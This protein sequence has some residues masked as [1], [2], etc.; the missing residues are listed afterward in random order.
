VSNYRLV[1]NQQV[2]AYQKTFLKHN[3]QSGPLSAHRE[4]RDCWIAIWMSLWKKMK[5]IKNERTDFCQKLKINSDWQMV[6]R[7]VCFDFDIDGARFK[8]K[9]PTLFPPTLGNIK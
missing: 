1:Q 4:T 5:K 9:T 6:A 7:E 2:H 8:I 3:T